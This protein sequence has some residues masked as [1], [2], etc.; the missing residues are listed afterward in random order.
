MAVEGD[1]DGLFLLRLI[2]HVK[3]DEEHV[4]DHEF[5][6]ISLL[7][8]RPLDARLGGVVAG[9]DIRAADEISVED[10]CKHDRE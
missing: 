5:G 4:T 3:A 7:G 2:S 1:F 10:A 9:G 6:E 8:E